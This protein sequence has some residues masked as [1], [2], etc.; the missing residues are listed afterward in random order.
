MKKFIQRSLALCTVAGLAAVMMGAN[1]PA[2]T[3]VVAETRTASPNE[4]TPLD[5]SQCWSRCNDC[6]RR[7]SSKKGDDRKNCE[8]N[9][10]DSN[11]NCCEANRKKGNYHSCGCN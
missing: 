3:Q 8:D 10:F 4:V 5:A 2:P 9:C 7:C 1:A 6:T 11:S